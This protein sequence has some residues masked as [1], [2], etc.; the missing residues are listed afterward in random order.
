MD[1]DIS[2]E[3]ERERDRAGAVTGSGAEVKVGQGYGEGQ[4]AEGRKCAG[5][6]AWGHAAMQGTTCN[7]RK[8]R[9]SCR[10]MVDVSC[11][12]RQLVRQR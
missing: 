9:G 1:R 6:G 7:G 3:R 11:A 2:R 10:A 8:V 4:I 12:Y 5:A